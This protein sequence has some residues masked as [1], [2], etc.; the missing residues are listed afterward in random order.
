MTGFPL[1]IAVAVL[2]ALAL[3][4]TVHE[5][6]VASHPV[7]LFGRAVGF[8]DGR[9]YRTPRAAGTAVAVASPLVSAGL[10]YGV[11]WVA[12]C[13]APLVAAVLAGVILWSTSSLWLL[14]D[15]GDRAITASDGDLETARETLPALVGRE[16]AELSP[17]LVRSAAV[18]SLA[19]N[20]SDG[21]VAPLFAFAV[22]SLI[23]L[24][25]AAAAATLV[26]A[27]NT[28]DSMLG[29]PGAFGWASARLDDA[30][31]WLPA[32]V[33]AVL[34]A[35]AGRDP[36]ALVRARAWA[37]APQSP[38]SGWPMATLA[39]VLDVR[40]DKPGAYVLNPD[41]SLPSTADARSGLR[42]VGV[43]GGL[44]FLAAGVVAWP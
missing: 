29:Y 12:L 39:A 9:D 10:V 26:K 21:L 24:P 7:S 8:F 33:S 16:T 35:A 30:V 15:A 17:E 1:G 5:P 28:L 34:L 4:W 41:A 11:S 14:L 36:D 38:N 20:L 25:A 31:M 37:R 2:L 27:I 40:L 19:E 42:V 18:E 6:P 13:V 32:R 3:D 23:S 44:A 43:A 22:F